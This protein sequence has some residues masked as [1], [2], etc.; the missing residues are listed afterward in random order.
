MPISV[1]TTTIIEPPQTYT[2]ANLKDL[3]R[4]SVKN[5]TQ[6]GLKMN[7][8]ATQVNAAYQNIARETHGCLLRHSISVPVDSN[9]LEVNENLIYV[10]HFSIVDSEGYYQKLKRIQYHHYLEK[11]AES[12][13]GSYPEYF[14]QAPGNFIYIYPV[15]S[16]AYTG[17]LEMSYVPDKMTD[18][19]D[20]CLLPYGLVVY[21]A[22]AT[23][24]KAV[25]NEPYVKHERERNR[26]IMLLRAE[27]RQEPSYVVP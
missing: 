22:A 2:F 27:Y 8:I 13:Q 7:L 21:H 26:L 24:V 15:A 1:S 23:E 25:L 18:N 16:R 20:E 4:S 19:E 14:A 3:V 6:L 9:S 10:R 12:T 17:T 11:M 5:Q